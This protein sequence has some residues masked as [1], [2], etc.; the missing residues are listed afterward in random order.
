M[1]L[2][3]LYVG[4]GWMSSQLSRLN[5]HPRCR[6]EVAQRLLADLRGQLGDLADL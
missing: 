6:L 3:R 2:D 5:G 4:Y 1:T